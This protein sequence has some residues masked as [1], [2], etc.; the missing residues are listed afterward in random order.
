MM[1]TSKKSSMIILILVD[2]KPV[3]MTNKVQSL[4]KNKKYSKELS[5]VLSMNTIMIIKTKI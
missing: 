1:F 3:K 2:N 5:E 4:L